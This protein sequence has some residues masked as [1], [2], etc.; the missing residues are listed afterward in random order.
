M[1]GLSRSEDEGDRFKDLTIGPTF[2]GVGQFVKDATELSLN[3]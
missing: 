3:S 2:F 1:F